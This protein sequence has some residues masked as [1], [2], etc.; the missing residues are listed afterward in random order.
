MFKIFRKFCV[1]QIV[2]NKLRATFIAM[3]SQKKTERK[4]KIIHQFG[5]F[6][7]KQMDK[8]KLK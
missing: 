2:K 6:Q 3:S 4:N 8:N 7:T 1:I 5:D